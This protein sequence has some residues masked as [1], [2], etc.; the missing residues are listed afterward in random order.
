[1][2]T[3]QGMSAFGE[4]ADI[5]HGTVIS[6]PDP[7]RHSLERCEIQHRLHRTELYSIDRGNPRALSITVVITATAHTSPR[8][9]DISGTETEHEC[10]CSDA[11]QQSHS[12]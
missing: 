4:I 7:K 3:H 1:M 2:A 12:R 5:R 10:E 8:A 9:D 11:K 6:V